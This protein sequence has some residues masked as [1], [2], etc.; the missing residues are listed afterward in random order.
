M[1]ATSIISFEI[2]TNLKDKLTDLVQNKLNLTLREFFTI[3]IKEFL[4]N[5]K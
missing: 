5:G 2:E 3:Q 4:K 1:K